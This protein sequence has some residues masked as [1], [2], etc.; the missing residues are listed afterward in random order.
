MPKSKDEIINRVHQ[1]RHKSRS[2]FFTKKDREL[3]EVYEDN[4][5]LTALDPI[6]LSKV[7]LARLEKKP[8][9]GWNFLAWKF[10]L[11]VHYP[12]EKSNPDMFGDISIFDITKELEGVKNEL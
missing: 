2:I 3:L 8:N 6:E 9:P 10:C 1:L 5:R 11:W 12:E 4:L 7:A